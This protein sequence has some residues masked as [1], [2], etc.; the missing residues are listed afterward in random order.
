MKIFLTHFIYSIFTSINFSKKKNFLNFFKIFNIRF[1]FSF[2]FIREFFN[3]KKK[4][5]EKIICDIPVKDNSIT[6]DTIVVDLE[7][8]GF[9]DK[10]I[11]SDK[12]IN[13]ICEEINTRN[14]TVNFKG[15][16]DKCNFLKE[17]NFEDEIWSILQ[18]SKR[19]N[20]SHVSLEIDIK[21][22]NLIFKLANSKFLKTV[23]K[24]YINDDNISVS[25]LCYLSNPIA[26]SENEKKDNAQY[27]HYDNDFKKFFKVFIYLN[28]VDNRSGPHTYLKYSHKNR[29]YR[30]IVSKRISDQEIK[31]LYDNENIV[32]FNRKKGT[33]IFEDTFG[34]HKGASPKSKS[35][36]VMILIYGQ[37]NGIGIYNNSI[38]IDD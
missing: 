13:L 22:T 17:L 15:D 2:I 4:I 25:S 27:Y 8:K 9:N 3:K 1:F 24:N 14:C 19:F 28:D 18:K 37:G 11:L 12:Y 6:S 31:A 21:K 35:R 30:H 34:L 7:K 26:I 29:L 10:L 38:M 23:A 20:L 16:K 36:A 5:Y 33:I 32:T